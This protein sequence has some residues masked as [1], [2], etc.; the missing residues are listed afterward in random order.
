MI[1]YDRLQLP[2][3]HLQLFFFSRASLKFNTFRIE[4]IDKQCPHEVDISGEAL[5]T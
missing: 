5:L 3:A 1:W 4:P 2:T